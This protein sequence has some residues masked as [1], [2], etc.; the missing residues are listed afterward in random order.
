MVQLLARFHPEVASLGPAAQLTN[1]RGVEVGR[2]RP[3][4]LAQLWTAALG[5]GSDRGAGAA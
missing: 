1:W 3:S 2:M 5:L 4:A